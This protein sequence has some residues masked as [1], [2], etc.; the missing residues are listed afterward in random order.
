MRRAG[1]IPG[2]ES[3]THKGPW[4]GDCDRLKGMEK[5]ISPESRHAVQDKAWQVSKDLY[6]A[7]VLHEKNGNHTS[8][9]SS[10]RINT[11]RQCSERK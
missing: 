1:N 4:L 7:G 3:N 8:D 10:A 6:Y 11:R 2:R 5:L 9:F